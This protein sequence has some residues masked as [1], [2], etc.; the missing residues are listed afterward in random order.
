MIL[1]CDPPRHAFLIHFGKRRQPNSVHTSRAER[2]G[3]MVDIAVNPDSAP[4]SLVA[5]HFVRHKFR[6]PFL[7]SKTPSSP[8]HF[9]FQS[10]RRQNQYFFHFSYEPRDCQEWHAAPGLTIL[11]SEPRR[12]EAGS[13]RSVEDRPVLRGLVVDTDVLRVD[14]DASEFVFECGADHLKDVSA[15]LFVEWTGG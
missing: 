6:L 13:P 15:T 2:H 14:V 10:G 7:D 12:P 5:I 4:P 11:I 1:S 9:H 8:D 3:A